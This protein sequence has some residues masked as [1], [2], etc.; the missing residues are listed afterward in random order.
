MLALAFLAAMR[1]EL[2]SQKQPCL[3]DVGQKLVWA[4]GW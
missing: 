1:V 4:C 2:A 3:F